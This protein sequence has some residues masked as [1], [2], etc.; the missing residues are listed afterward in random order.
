MAEKSKAYFESELSGIAPC[1][2]EE[3]I[4]LFFA[5]R[6]GDRAAESRF[7]EGNLHRVYEA[8]R[9]FASQ[10]IPGMDLVQ[11]G[12]LALL[13]SFRSLESPSDIGETLDAAIREAME[14]FVTEETNSTA[15]SRELVRRLNALDELTVEMSEKLER[16]PSAEELAAVMDMDPDDIRYLMRIA[17]TAINK[18]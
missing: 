4:S 14:R 8:A 7:I 17:L 13:L 5:D 15:A 9:Y 3:N 12:S 1:T 6:K 18:D 2:D 11:E 16:E 10:D